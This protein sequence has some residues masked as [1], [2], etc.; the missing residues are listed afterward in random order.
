VSRRPPIAQRPSH[1]RRRIR[2][3]EGGFA[4][5]KADWRFRVRIRVAAQAEATGADAARGAF[6][7]RRAAAF[8]SRA[9]SRIISFSMLVFFA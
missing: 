6:S 3:A 7:L 9:M 8:T 5:P 4:S 1:R 2:I